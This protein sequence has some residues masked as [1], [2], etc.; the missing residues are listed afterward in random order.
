MGLSNHDDNFAMDEEDLN[1]QP[2]TNVGDVEESDI[3]EEV[4]ENEEEIIHGMLAG[5]EN[6]G[7]FL[8][9]SHLESYCVCN[10]VSIL[11]P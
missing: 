3:R 10:F 11:F 4:E 8:R 6:A 2:S 1:L 9:F 5:K 7:T